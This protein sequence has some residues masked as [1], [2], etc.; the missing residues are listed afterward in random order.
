MQ[1]AISVYQQLRGKTYTLTPMVPGLF[2]WSVASGDLGKAKQ[3][4]IERVRK[5]L[6]SV[7]FALFTRLHVPA[8]RRLTRQ[9]L[10][11]VLRDEG[12]KKR[13]SGFFPVVLEERASSREG[14]LALAYHPLEPS[15]WFETSDQEALSVTASYHFSRIFSADDDVERLR[16]SGSEKLVTLRFRAEAPSLSRLLKSRKTTDERASSGRSGELAALLRVAVNQTA[17]AASGDLKLGLPRESERER[18]RQLL[19]GPSKAPVLV[20]GPPGSGKSTL[21]AQAVQ[22]LLEADDFAAHGN[23][24][25]VHN[26][27]AMGGRQIIA[28]MSY[29]GQWEARC[30][31]LL[32]RCK[33]RKLLLWLD[34]VPAFGSIGKT[35][36]SD[37]T[38]AD[39]F[40]GPLARRELI[41]I[42]ECTPEQLSLL[43]HDTPAFAATFSVVQLEAATTAQT[44]SMLLFESR[45]LE[46]TLDIAFDPRA[47]HAIIEQSRALFSGTALPGRALAPL[48]AMAQSAARAEAVE[49]GAV[50]EIGIDHVLSAFSSQTGLPELLLSPRDSLTRASLKAELAQQI[51]GQEVALDAA[52]DL[53]LSLRSKLC[54]PARPYGVFLF[55]GPTG[56]GKTELAKCLA[57]YLYGAA[58]RLLRFDMGELGTPDAVARLIGDQLEPDGLL[59]SRVR[60]QPFCVLLFDEVEKAHP[61]VLNLMLQIFEDARLGDARGHVTDFSH[62]VIVMTSNLG[63]GRATVR[64]FSEGAATLGSDIAAAVREFF[65][66]ELFNRIDRVVPFAPL[67]SQAARAIV[68]KELSMLVARPGLSERSTFVRFTDAV[69]TRVLEDGYSAEYGARALK[70]YIDREIG[71]ALT[72]AI[73]A[74][75]PAEMRLLW[76]YAQPESRGVGMRSEVLREAA[77][78]SEPSPLLELLSSDYEQLRARVPAA[79]ARLAGFEGDGRLERL[80]A[81]LSA[82]LSLYRIGQ[83][84]RAS[85]IFNLDSL[86]E[87]A[88][89]LTHRMEALLRGD[90]ELEALERRRKLD[91]GE[92]LTELDYSALGRE[93]GRR[94]EPGRSSSQEL[95]DTRGGAGRARALLGDLAEVALLE[96]LLA[97]ANEPDRHVVLVEVLK[98]SL[99]HER[100][101]FSKGAPG[102]A[103]WLVEAYARSRGELDGA[104]ALFWDGTTKSLAPGE[105]DAALAE[106]PQQVALR[107]VG[108]GVAD[109]LRGE[110]GCHVRRT[111]SAGP[112]IVRIRV[113]P[114]PHEPLAWVESHRAALRA[115][116]R[117]LEG[118]GPLTTNPEQLLPVI[119]SLRFDPEP[120]QLATLWLEDYR[121]SHVTA[122]RVRHVRELLAQ[123][124]L[125]G[126]GIQERAWPT[127]E[128]SA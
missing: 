50:V 62:C 36:V 73:A 16:S 57:E 103:E 119:R 85:E 26:V 6:V 56:T 92:L 125:L 29:V 32:Q 21:I 41:A 61:S 45:R 91:Q 75:A 8:G 27:L 101:R 70:R 93:H 54:G 87:H 98:L 64:G 52:C 97:S 69:V 108:P 80:G 23:L 86:R 59:T 71:G 109:F 94:F 17:R 2:A 81:R 96:G 44:L 122:R 5:E 22:D 118:N 104:A 102:L 33:K 65:P 105:L 15:A 13:V 60:A 89:R 82:E 46:Q 31:E 66:P 43:Q 120:E 11:L 19:C 110:T 90:A 115:F 20:V 74:D 18:L 14:T 7:D 76:L 3:R 112:E 121:L 111:L 24:D 38:L 117:G 127:T 49:P 123:L 4:L 10:E 78:H 28:G 25:R 114:G 106:R 55:T 100:R 53:I 1:I 37:R 51:M 72:H 47:F 84:G 9:H 128:V 79:L 63:T 107:L 83:R 68:K 39:F 88:R 113:V 126:A 34:D 12:E 95:A 58:E 99:H 40:Q 35:T 48:K 124:W 116:E 30:V 77:P 67:D 42:G